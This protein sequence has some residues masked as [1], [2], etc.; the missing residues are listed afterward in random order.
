MYHANSNNQIS[1]IFLNSNNSKKTDGAYEF[2]LETSITCPLSQNLLLSL[3]E[4]QTPNVLPIFDSTNNIFNFSINSPFNNSVLFTINLII[5]NSIMNP[6]D[7]ANYV[8]FEY[9]S[10]RPVENSEFEFSVFFN[11]QT[12]IL[13]F[14]SNTHFKILN[15]TASTILGLNDSYPILATQSPAYSIRQNPVNFIS[16]NNI[17]IKTQ[18]FTLNNI[19]SYG[20]ITNT[21]AR[22]PVNCNP[23]GIIFY[24]PVELNKFIIPSRRLKKLTFNFENDRNQPINNLH[25]Q[26]MLKIDY[27]FPQIKEESPEVGTINYYLKNNVLPQEEQVEPEPFGV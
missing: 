18:E 13:E 22:V 17:F 19:N 25:F 14:S 5:P 24:R 11:R 7:F 21:F 3:I 9:L 15:S 12:F 4:F 10:L 16:T 6:V 27:I 26:I 23:G 20:Q 8:N 2:D 1:T